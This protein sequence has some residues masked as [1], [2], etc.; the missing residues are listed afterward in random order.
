MDPA[1]TRNANRGQ[2]PIV[3]TSIALCFARGA[4]NPHSPRA[5]LARVIRTIINC[6]SS[7]KLW[8]PECG[9]DGVIIAV[10]GDGVRVE[11]R[12]RPY[13]LW[14]IGEDSPMSKL[15]S[16][17]KTVNISQLHCGEVE[18]MT[19]WNKEWPEVYRMFTRALEESNAP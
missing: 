16:L 6:M 1:V 11:F 14:E 3:S 5:I 19:P 15:H 18:T 13:S 2:S 9:E 10:R 17:L 12:G 4:H 8:M 7:L